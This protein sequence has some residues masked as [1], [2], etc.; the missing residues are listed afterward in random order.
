MNIGDWV[1]CN[2]CG[3]S[4]IGYIEYVG[5]LEADVHIRI[6]TGEIVLRRSAIVFPLPFLLTQEDEQD[7]N[8]LFI[9]LA[10][11]R[12]DEQEFMKLT[13]K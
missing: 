4:V 11:A 13:N 9:D 5:I 1:K 6:L 3:E 10:I 12:G 7:V 2:Y 8:N